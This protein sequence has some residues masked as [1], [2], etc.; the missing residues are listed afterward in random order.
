[1]AGDTTYT[2]QSLLE[3]SVDGVSPDNAEAHRTLERILGYARSNPAVYLPSHGP[4][5]MKRLKSSQK[6]CRQLPRL[7]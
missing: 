3:Q 5:S 4:E 2:R 7:Q 6:F 1:M